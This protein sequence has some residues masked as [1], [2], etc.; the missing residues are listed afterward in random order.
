MSVESP[1][2]RY[3]S[4]LPLAA[5]AIVTACRSDSPTEVSRSVSSGNEIVITEG[6]SVPMQAPKPRKPSLSSVDGSIGSTVVGSSTTPLTLTPSSC[7]ETATGQVTAVFLTTGNQVGTATFDVYTKATYQNGAWS[8]SDPVTI[9]VPP[10]SSGQNPTPPQEDQVTITLENASSS[11]AGTTVANAIFNPVSITNSNIT[12]GKLAAG[13]GAVV[14]VAFADCAHTNSP[15][16]LTV[17]PD[18]VGV[19]AT[20]SAG[21]V[22]NFPVIAEDTE[23]GDLTASVVCEPASGSTFPLGTTTVSCHVTDSGGLEASGTFTVEV[24]DTRSAYFTSFPA[25]TVNLVA[26]DIHGATLDVGSLGISVEDSGHVSEPSTYSCD[27]VAGTVLEI[28]STTTVSCRASDAI[29]NR[30]DASTFDVFVGLNVS[31]TGFLSPLRMSSPFS[32]HKRGSTIPH[33]FL[34]PT[35]AD[36]TPAT[37]LASGLHLVITRLDGTVELGTIEV[38]DY[39]AGSTV[40]RYDDLDAQYIFNLKSVTD[41]ATGTWRTAVSYKGVTLATTDFNLK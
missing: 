37:D 32:S 3:S 31:G 2:V 19:Q 24:I 23:D 12:G 15:P 20:S 33:K 26:A 39:S 25:G 17:S 5:L 30:S 13:T 11:G 9:T 7:A 10:R 35:Y 28:G 36:G 6:A 8:Y 29:G 38:N 41:W 34:P 21:A 18:I 14:H 40:W 16:V 4:V 22:V 1:A 27:Y